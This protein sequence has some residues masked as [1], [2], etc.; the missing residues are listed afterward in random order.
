MAG[1]SRRQTF[2][3]TLLFCSM[4]AVGILMVRESSLRIL[5][6]CLIAMELTRTFVRPALWRYI[7]M[8]LFTAAGIGT[9]IYS[10]V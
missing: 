4:M 5:F 6:G 8:G 1:L 10:L 7:L 2:V 3:W 9:V